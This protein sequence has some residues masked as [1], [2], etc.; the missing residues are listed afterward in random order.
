MVFQVLLLQRA[1]RDL[2]KIAAY[3]EAEL[4]LA[5]SDWFLGLTQAVMSLERLPKRG[6]LLGG[7]VPR[8]Q[9]LYGT[10]PHLYRSYSS[11]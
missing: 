9:I 11:G 8:R 5:A 2:Q 1:E 10:R 4:N 3:V 6:T 7:S